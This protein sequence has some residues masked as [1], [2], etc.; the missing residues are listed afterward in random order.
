M[1]TQE[2]LFF[3]HSVIVYIIKREEKKTETKVSRR[4]QDVKDNN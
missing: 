1:D 4:V 2:I 3:S